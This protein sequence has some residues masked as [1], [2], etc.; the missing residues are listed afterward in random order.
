MNNPLSILIV[1]DE[2]DIND[3]LC[4]QLRREGH[5]V[6]QAFHGSQAMDLLNK[7]KYNF[8]ILDWMLPG[9]SGLEILRNLRQ[10]KIS[11][12]LPVIMIT[13]KGLTDDVVRGLECGA[14]DYIVKPFDVNI[15][16]ARMM[17]ILRRR[18]TKD[19]ESQSHYRVGSLELDL[20][21][22]EIALHGVVLDLTI[23]EFRLLSSLLINQGRV[24]TRKDLMQQ[25]Q[26]D[27]VNVV[28]RSIDT[29]VVGIRKKLGDDSHIIHTVRGLGY[30]IQVEAK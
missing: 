30:K 1:E 23:S 5:L 12:S 21:K 8:L 6:A 22:H 20:E 7:E 11:E 29:H 10:N 18:N 15:L 25:I 26:G 3:L 24:M 16:K 4:L 14:D 19:L 17:A 9:L 13:A 2:K 27:G 28:E